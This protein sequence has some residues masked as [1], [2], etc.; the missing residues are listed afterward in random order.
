MF[1][2]EA[3]FLRG[4]DMSFLVPSGQN[5]FIM[6]EPKTSWIMKWKPHVENGRLAIPNTL[7]PKSYQN[8]PNQTTIPYLSHLPR[9]LCERSI[10]LLYITVFF[11][12]FVIA[13]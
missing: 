8:I 5:V 10:S 9:L 6:M 3:V 13:A 12:F 1:K 7:K 2:F 4:G 11:Y